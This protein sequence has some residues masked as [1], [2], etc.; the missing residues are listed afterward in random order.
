MPGCNG[1]DLAAAIR[2]QDAYDSI[3]IVFLTADA[4]A[5]KHLAALELG[6]D[7]YL[8]KPLRAEHVSV[9]VL[10]RLQRARLLRTY[11]TRDS[12]TG[13]YNHTHL[14]E[15]LELALAR[16]RRHGGPFAFAMV[17]LDRFKSVNDTHGHLAGDR[18]IK[19]LSTLLK[20]RLRNT[21]LIGRYG[22]EEFAV[23]LGGVDAAGAVQVLDEIR[24]A[25]AGLR[26]RT[27][28]GGEFAVTLSAGVAAYP[29][30]GELSALIEAADRAL[31]RAKE[32]GRNCILPAIS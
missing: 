13:L 6:G 26:H 16:A 7:D 11:M 24:R 29:G 4:S 25:F 9:S 15:Q 30:H 19:S 8:L 12:L 5:E 10:S 18:V 2:Q 21:D 22:G 14:Q 17:D 1:L 3:P 28:D 32:Q 23:I 27:G 20:Q 31:Y